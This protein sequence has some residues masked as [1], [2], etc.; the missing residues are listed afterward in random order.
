[1]PTPSDKVPG[2]PCKLCHKPTSGA[3]GGGDVYHAE[4]LKKLFPNSKLEVI[5]EP[6]KK[7]GSIRP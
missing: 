7:P 3:W 6:R 1:M 4:C 2:V 5:N